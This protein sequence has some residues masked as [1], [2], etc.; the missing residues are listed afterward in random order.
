MQIKMQLFEIKPIK[1]RK[2]CQIGRQKGFGTAFVRDKEGGDF[3][4]M[5][6]DL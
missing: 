5:I 3:K 1:C 2:D 6:Y 4:F